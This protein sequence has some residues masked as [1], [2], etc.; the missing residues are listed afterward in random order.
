MLFRSAGPAEVEAKF[1]VAPS[2]IADYLALAG[3]SVDNIPG[4]PGVGAKT[5]AKILNHFGDIDALYRS[6]D[7]VEA[8]DIRGAAR[9]RETLAQHE[10][11]VR[12]FRDITRIKTDIEID[13][14]L[15]DLK[16]AA[17]DK[18]GLDA[19]CDEMNFGQRMRKR[20]A[21]LD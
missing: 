14:K 7:Q 17:P 1:G 3:D 12:M 21:S 9:V 13:V 19:F 2:Q 18:S 15:S 8:I 20:L 5:A 10:E 4:A 11:M 16:Q 6:L